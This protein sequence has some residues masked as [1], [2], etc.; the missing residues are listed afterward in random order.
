MKTVVSSNYQKPSFCFTL[1]LLLC[2][3]RLNPHWARSVPAVRV[4]WVLQNWGSLHSLTLNFHLL[5]KLYLC[6]EDNG[7]KHIALQEFVHPEESNWP[8]ARGHYAPLPLFFP[9]FDVILCGVSS[10]NSGSRVWSLEDD[11]KLAWVTL[12]EWEALVLGIS[13]IFHYHRSACK[14]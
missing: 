8:W 5:I 2:V 7:R 9:P 13:G 14:R 10:L 4:P 11:L 12:P 6:V 3:R 1:L